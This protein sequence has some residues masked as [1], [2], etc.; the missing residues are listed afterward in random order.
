MVGMFVNILT[1]QFI[2]H[3]AI[4]SLGVG[5]S[6]YQILIQIHTSLDVSVSM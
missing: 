3:T 4:P 2:Q 1:M 6:V 5:V